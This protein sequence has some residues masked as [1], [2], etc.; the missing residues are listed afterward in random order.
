MITKQP[1]D[2]GSAGEQKAAINLEE[3]YEK[4]TEMVK[5][6]GQELTKPSEFDSITGM[7][8]QNIHKM[9]VLSKE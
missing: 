8:L 7:L 3:L 5:A 4:F 9:N 2:E 6:Q 1:A